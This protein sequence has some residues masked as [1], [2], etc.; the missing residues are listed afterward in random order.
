M[1]TQTILFD[2]NETVL[3]LSLLK[4][5][6]HQYFGCENHMNTWFS[7]LLHSSTVCLV[8]NT[9]SNFKSLALSALKSM[10]GRLDKNI[11]DEGYQDILSTFSRL[12]AHDDIQPAMKALKQAG[13]RLVALSNSSS[14]LLRSQLTFSGL[15]DYFDEAISVEQANT[16]K[17]AKT[18]YHFALQQ[19]QIEPTQAR[20]VATHDWDTHGALSAG[21]KAAYIDRSGAPYNS[22]YLVPD[23]LSSNMGDIAQQIMIKEM[24]NTV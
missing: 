7:M 4:P 2:I 23:I 12:P 11:S 6:F 15:H 3:N 13:Y 9:K 21:L 8:T 24:G 20:L 5:K 10:A 19:L 16:F 17:P 14:E 1:P 22:H 18:A